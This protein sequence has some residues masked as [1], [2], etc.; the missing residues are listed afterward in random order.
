MKLVTLLLHLLAVSFV[1]TGFAA[2]TDPDSSSDLVESAFDSI[3][4][5]N[6]WMLAGAV[7]SGIFMAARAYGPW[8]KLL[9]NDEDL[10]E[11]QKDLRGFVGIAVLAI[12]AGFGHA[13]LAGGFDAINKELI[14]GIVKT[15][16]MATLTYAAGKKGVGPILKKIEAAK[17]Q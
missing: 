17:D 8:K 6:W 4:N 13:L 1:L 12:T 5:G 11:H 7:L 10:A 3:V 15:L 9:G 16:A 14:V 2:T